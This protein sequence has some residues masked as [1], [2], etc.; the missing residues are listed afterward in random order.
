M[1]A[2]PDATDDEARL[3]SLV[4]PPSWRNASPPP[5]YAAARFA[6]LGVDVHFGEAP[7]IAGDAVAVGDATLRFRK[8]VIATG[9]RAALPP[10]AGLAGAAPRTNE[11][12]FD[13]GARPGRLVV[14]GGGPIG[15]ELAQAFAGHGTA[16]TL[17]EG[18]P[19]LLARDE[20]DA[21]RLVAAS[22]VRGGT[23]VRTSARITAVAREADGAV[24]VAY[25]HDGGMHVATGDE[26]LVAAGR[27][28]N[29][30]GLD[31]ERADV[32]S[33]RQGITVDA[34]LR[35]S[36]PRIFAIG[37]VL[38]GA[39]FTHVA[40]A[41]AR[42][43]VANALF[44]GI[45]GGRADRLVVPRVTYTTPEV[46]S[47]GVV[48]GASAAPDAHA[49]RDAPAD[50]VRVDFAHVDR[51]V[52]EDATEGFLAVHLRRGG[53]RI[54]GATIVGEHAGELLMPLVHAMTHGIGLGALGRT[55]HPYPTR[56][57]IVRKAADQYRRRALTPGR[58]AL[59]RR[60]LRWLA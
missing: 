18:G 58:A 15:C 46:A 26:L 47:V 49:E 44:R 28:P 11:T 29:V 22:L 3:L 33:S 23:T 50:V 21:A 2:P 54:V 30:E 42:L 12:I 14:I 34:T 59:L 37:D 39:Q 5:R 53:D 4:Q 9:A 13:L 35:T 19:R 40:D 41:H 36:N 43:V 27:A 55:I 57:E 1:H 17:L 32:A 31:L 56:S 10:I 60:A 16:V 20:P 48:A 24:R 45:G 51:A 7:F 6:G 25:E 38:G 8:A 52:V